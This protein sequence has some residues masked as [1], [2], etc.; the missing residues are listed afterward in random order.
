MPGG[1]WVNG[2]LT[3][4][5]DKSNLVGY[6]FAKWWLDRLDTSKEFYFGP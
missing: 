2:V 6:H 1:W 3:E 4:M 5:A